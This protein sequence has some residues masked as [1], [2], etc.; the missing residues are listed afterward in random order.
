MKRHPR[1]QTERR[2]DAGPVRNLFGG[3]TSRFVIVDCLTPSVAIAVQTASQ[4][5]ALAETVAIKTPSA[6]GCVDTGEA[7][8]V[9]ADPD[10]RATF[11]NIGKREDASQGGGHSHGAQA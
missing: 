6:Y 2:S 5:F 10:W 7:R 1:A 9:A 3:L 8:A 4:L 11:R